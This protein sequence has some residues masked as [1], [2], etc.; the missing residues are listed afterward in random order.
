[1]PVFIKDVVDVCHEAFGVSSCPLCRLHNRMQTP[2]CRHGLHS[3]IHPEE[4]AATGNPAEHG[5]R[6][7][8]KMM[9]K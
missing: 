3:E 8:E 6:G 4:L 7:G 2:D 9:N 1:M 5:R